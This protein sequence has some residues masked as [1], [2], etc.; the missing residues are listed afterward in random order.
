MTTTH[1][2]A[3][4]PATTQLQIDLDKLTTILDASNE[5]WRAVTTA[6]TNVE[7]AEYLRI[8]V[9][10]LREFLTVLDEQTAG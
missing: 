9:K 5:V 2:Q 3:T 6:Q 4:A 10:H 1:T 8:H 7:R